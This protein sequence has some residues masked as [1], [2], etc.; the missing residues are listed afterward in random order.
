MKMMSEQ[1]RKDHILS[2]IDARVKLVSALVLLAMVLSYKGFVFPLATTSLCL[3]LCITLRVPVRVFI[4]RFSEPLF[5][6][7]VI[8]LL[9]FF[10]SGKEILFSVHFGIDIVG[11]RDGLV[12]GLMIGSRIMAAVSVV[13]LLGFSTP[14][15]EFMAGLSWL[16][17]PRGF[18]EIM[19]FAYRYIF[20]LFEDATV[21][22]NAQKNRLGYSSLKRGLSSFGVLAGS[23]TLKAFDHSQNTTVAM[24]QRGYDGN[25]PMLKH[26]SFQ[27]S[28]IAASIVFMGGMG[29]L[30]NL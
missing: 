3:F 11:Y 21:I 5:L 23:L 28:E 30:W 4:L 18:I 25:M 10:F 26:K 8:L 9:K 24:V 15:A 14:F 6:A 22:Y 20:V 19:M 1:A 2:R 17:V 12:E 27:L 16:R 7:A 29:L 13:A